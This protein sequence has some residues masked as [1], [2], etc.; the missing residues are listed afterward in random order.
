MPHIK[1]S[2]SH[3]ASVNIYSD[4]GG[5]QIPLGIIAV[6]SEFG[7]VSKADQNHCDCL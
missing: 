5:V 4:H 3:I 6:S 2:I 7:R 1:R